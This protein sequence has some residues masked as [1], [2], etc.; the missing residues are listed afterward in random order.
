M[1]RAPRLNVTALIL[2]LVTAAVWAPDDARAGGYGLYLEADFSDASIDK[3]FSFSEQGF[4]FSDPNFSFSDEKTDVGFEAA[5]GGIGFIYDTNVA[6][7]E[8]LNYRVK[9]GF[10]V[11][12]RK[13]DDKTPISIPGQVPIADDMTGN[14]VNNPITFKPKTETI[15]GLTL[16]HTLGYGF[17]R[18]PSFR[19]WAGPTMRINVDWYGATT[20]LDIV[21]VSVGG[22]PEIGFNYHL[23]DQLS[24]STSLAYNYLYISEHFETTGEDRRLEGSQH[25]L[26]LSV[27]LLFRTESDRWSK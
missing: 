3:Q 11:G 5:M 20:D 19:I 7:D 23:S 13:P 17:M 14:E 4:I 22:G 24:L 21:D 18:R 9:M 10:R 25:L 8:P 12:R 15:L 2:A 1:D 27:S 26:A 6:R 16:N